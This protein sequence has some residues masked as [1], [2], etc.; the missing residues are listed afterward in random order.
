VSEN[1]LKLRLREMRNY[2]ENLSD[3]HRR[4]LEY[5]LREDK[6]RLLEDIRLLYEG[7]FFTN[8]ELEEIFDI[9]ELSEKERTK[10]TY[11]MAMGLFEMVFNESSSGMSKPEVV[12]ELIERLKRE[13]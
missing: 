10:I 8:E 7:D 1:L 2:F 13:L 6:E 9:L 4:V 5:R 11:R 12:R 3:N